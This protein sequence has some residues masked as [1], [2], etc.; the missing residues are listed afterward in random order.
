[1]HMTSA[2]TATGTPLARTAE[3]AAAIIGG[4]CKASWLKRMAREG[5]IGA[6]KIG[7]AWNF[8]DAHIAQ[9]MRLCEVPASHPAQHAPAPL[10]VTAGRQA[11]KRAAAAPVPAT[12]A[13][14]VTQLRARPIRQRG[15]A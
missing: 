10:P 1:M 5:K 9:V 14:R 4:S 15:A 12:P 8:T 13:G 2:V 7:G 3:E 11:A 6:L